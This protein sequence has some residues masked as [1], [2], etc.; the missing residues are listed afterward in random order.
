VVLAFLGDIFE[1]I[2]LVLFIHFGIRSREGRVNV[3]WCD[4]VPCSSAPF[5][6]RHIFFLPRSIL[7]KRAAHEIGTVGEL[8]AFRGDRESAAPLPPNP[9]WAKRLARL[10]N[11][12]D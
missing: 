6:V 5:E 12:I 10:I 4:L 1:F 9:R 8:G 2:D 11:A 7:V 3:L